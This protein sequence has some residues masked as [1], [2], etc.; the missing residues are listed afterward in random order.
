MSDPIRPSIGLPPD[1]TVEFFRAKGDYLISNRWW[2]VWQ[3]EHARAFTVAGITDRT[4]LE[5]VRGSLDNMIAG[6]GTFEM[7]KA[8]TLPALK[9]AVE[10]GTAPD[11]ILSDARLRTIYTMNLRMARAAG[12][13]KRIQAIKHLAPYLMYIAIKDDHTR[14]QHRIWGGLD[15]GRPIILPVDHP[16]W[17]WLFPP[18]GWGCRCNVI[19]LSQRDFDARKA[20]VTTEGELGELGLPTL[21]NIG[22]DLTGVATRDFIRGD[23]I[24]ERVPNGIDPGFAYNVGRE[25]LRGLGDALSNSLETLAQNNVSYAQAVLQQVVDQTGFDTLLTA[26]GAAFP[27]MILD[28]AT[29]ALFGSKVR[30]ARLSN[31]T[32]AK[33]LLKHGELTL[34]DYRKLVGIGAKP[35]LIIKQDEL[36]IIL[37]KS[38]GGTWLKAAVKASKNRQE[39]YVVSY[40]FARDQEVERLIRKYEV[41]FD[42]RS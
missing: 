21:R 34:D 27:V 19:Q 16:A 8:E 23:G 36:H 18:N 41:I 15:N 42:G 30:V 32:Y 9:A 12:K 17:N 14:P 3:E 33:Q 7:W 31:T 37:I 20:S 22:G 39:L 38:D 29:S 5:S 28:D 10:N 2:E 35:D 13:W 25:H 11:N 26:K 1:E 24:I 4:V 40:Q 6:G